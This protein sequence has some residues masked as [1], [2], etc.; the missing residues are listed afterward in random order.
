MKTI[1]NLITF[2]IIMTP[3]IAQAQFEASGID[4][5][6]FKRHLKSNL[7]IS[8][9]NTY[10]NIQGTPFMF[11]DFKAGSVKLLNSGVYEGMFQ[12]DRYAGEIHFKQKNE[13]FAIAFP[14]KIE[15]IE[16]DGIRFIYSNYKLSEKLPANEEGSYFI[17]M[18]DEK[19]KLLVKKVTKIRDAK[20]SKGVKEA[21]PAKFITS[22]DTY[23]IK[24]GNLA[25]VKIT[26]KNSLISILGDKKTEISKF[27]SKE[28]ISHKKLK[29]LK[30]LILYYNN[31]TN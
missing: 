3:C 28:K 5:L 22:K 1:F 12:F 21:T 26:N 24:T 10:S 19:C 17:V 8:K 14:D 20:P 6:F 27:I 31:I 13:T 9:N 11:K 18:V 4:D 7:E 2:L 29:D 30:K 16:I 23:F 15:Y 25:A